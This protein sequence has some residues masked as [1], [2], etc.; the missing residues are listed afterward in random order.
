[1]IIELVKESDFI[2]LHKLIAKT[3]RISFEP[4]YPES[5]I[6]KV[7]QSL[8]IETLK[9]RAEWTH[10]YVFKENENIIGCGAIGPY[11]GS[12]IESS[13][14]TIFV[15]PDHQGKGIGRL[16]MQTLENDEYFKRA[17]RI[18]IP[19]GMVALPFYKKMGYTHKNGE[20]NYED[21]HFALEKFNKS[22]K[23]K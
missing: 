17:K 6:E 13:L 2:N 5:F 9:R 1:M 14:F 19:A 20:L 10:F 8:N 15:D 21:G 23:S 16:I 18:E 11:W 7:I 3:C 12:E 22:F 4:Y